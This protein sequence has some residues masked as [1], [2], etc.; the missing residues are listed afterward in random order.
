MEEKKSCC[1]LESVVGRPVSEIETPALVVDL[2]IMESNM[3]KMMQFLKDS[4]AGVGIRPHA[5]THKIPE[6]A[7]M[8]LERGAL[9]IC[10]AKLGEA[11]AMVE[12]G[13]TNIFIANQTIGE[14]KLR[15]LVALSKKCD[16]KVAV[17]TKEN[18]LDISRISAAQGGRVGIV[19]EVDSGNHRCGV[20]THAGAIELA[21]LAST[22][23]GVY[24]AGL[25]GYEGHAVFMPSLEERQAVAEK[26]YDVLLGYRDAVK[27]A[28][29]LDSGIVSAA[30][31]GTYMFGGK[32]KGLT[33][34]EAGSYIF[35]DARYGGT[36]GVD[37]R[38][39]LAVLATIISH[40]EPDLYIC[41][42]G[43]KSMTEEFGLVATLPSYGLKV[44][45]MSEEHVSLRST[46]EPVALPG[47]VDL[48]AKYG[49][50]APKPLKV[51]DKILLIPSH[52]CT[53]VNLHD[54]M[55]A[56]RDGKVEDVWRVTG[57]GKFA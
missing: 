14:K 27:E 35:M 30:G 12:G 57:R 32:R 8:Q 17:D 26:A 9:D 18:L 7:K 51:G 10:C 24:Y 2:G 41:D 46:T 6:I 16:L 25:M 31:S 13:V 53:T 50:T 22:L 44:V 4:G 47:L 40:P 38:N 55:Y 15:R 39:S 19:V 3:D 23:P 49:K 1:S 52:C 11:E 36:A 43:I 34:I 21:K 42:A 45:H 56:I 28:T 48:D 5:K 29:G 37:F 54:V 33:D 20:R